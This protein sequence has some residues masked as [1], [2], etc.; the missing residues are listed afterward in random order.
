MR[1]ETP[2]SACGLAHILPV[3]RL[4][5]FPEKPHDL[6]VLEGTH[7][8]ETSFLRDRNCLALPPAY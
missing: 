4:L 6:L 1:L 7:W 5:G 2:S 8:L 3:G